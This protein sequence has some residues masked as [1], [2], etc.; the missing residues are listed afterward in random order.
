MYLYHFWKRHCVWYV[1]LG[2]PLV[3]PKIHHSLAGCYCI[4]RRAQT[5]RSEHTFFCV[6]GQVSAIRASH[7]KLSA[8]AFRNVSGNVL[9]TTDKCTHKHTHSHART[10]RELTHDTHGLAKC[11]SYA[12]K[13]NSAHQTRCVWISRNYYLNEFLY[14]VDHMLWVMSAYVQCHSVV[15]GQSLRMNNTP[16][17]P[18]SHKCHTSS[19]Y[20]RTITQRAYTH[21]RFLAH[22]RPDNTRTPSFVAGHYRCLQHPQ[23]PRRL[24]RVRNP[25]AGSQI[26]PLSFS[27]GTCAASSMCHLCVC[28]CMCEC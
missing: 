9:E 15:R 3:R 21:F 11:V 12:M 8:S 20:S 2:V 26:I 13:V 4:A 18:H 17:N 25:I 16:N 28:V 7:L 24:Q 10:P 23:Q 19:R 1:L 6:V 5:T 22:F 14:S 27:L